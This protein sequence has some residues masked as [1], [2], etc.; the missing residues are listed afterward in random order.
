MNGKVYLIGAGPGD[1]DLLTRKAWQLL[2][3]ADVVLHDELVS[4]DVLALAPPYAQVLSVGKRCGRRSV[5]QDEINSLMVSCAQSG[6]AV[7]R[8][9]GGDPEIFGRLGE[10][11]A[12]LREAAID[13]EIVPGVTAAFAAAASAGIPLTDRRFASELVFLTGHRAPG[14]HA[15]QGWRRLSSASTVV[16]YMPGTDYEGLAER[17]CEAGLSADTPCLIVA[18]AS[19]PEERRQLTTLEHL[20]QAWLNA[21]PAVLIIGAVAA[22]GQRPAEEL[23]EAACVTL[24]C[25]GANS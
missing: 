9:K 11:V 19:R 20:P 22:L 10:E 16:V 1:P 4:R 23:E 21:A 8:L 25:A 2:Q 24:A 17:L 5:T 3:A 6:L 15:E 14:Q 12:A 7:V 13:F 18:S